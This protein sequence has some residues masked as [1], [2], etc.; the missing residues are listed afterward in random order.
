M[1][2]DISGKVKKTAKKAKG[3][4]KKTKKEKKTK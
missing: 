1:S 4:V 3:L 2:K